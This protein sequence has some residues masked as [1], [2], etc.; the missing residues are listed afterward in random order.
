MRSL[1]VTEITYICNIAKALKQK[2]FCILPNGIA[3]GI[4]NIDSYLIYTEIDSGILC[5]HD[6]YNLIFDSRALSAYYKNISFETDITEIFNTPIVQELPQ[7]L[8]TR[9][10]NL[11]NRM[12]ALNNIMPLCGREC[13]DSNVSGLFKLTKSAGCIYYIHHNKYMITLF[14]SMLPLNKNDNI[15]LTLYPRDDCSYIAKFDVV[16]KQTILHI[17]FSYLYL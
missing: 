13:I 17:F 11:V 5:N 6:A 12:I 1:K 4:D 7:Y 15:Y 10:M 9:Y 3:V 16:K 14:S 8:S 2:R